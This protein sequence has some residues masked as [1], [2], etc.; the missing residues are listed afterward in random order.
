MG[1]N[2]DNTKYSG[3]TYILPV[4]DQILSATYNFKP[5]SA[6]KAA[7]DT[8]ALSTVTQSFQ[9][10]THVSF[11]IKA[12]GVYELTWP[13]YATI[14]GVKWAGTNL[15]HNNSLESYPWVS[16]LWDGTSIPTPESTLSNDS[17][18]DYWRWNVLNVDLD[19][20]LADLP[21][22]SGTTWELE[23]DPCRQGLGGTWRVPTKD[24]LQSLTDAALKNKWVRINNEEPQRTNKSGWIDVSELRVSGTVHAEKPN[25]VIFLP[26]AGRR[27]GSKYNPTEEREGY[28]W[29]STLD[30]PAGSQS[31]AYYLITWSKNLAVFSFQRYRGAS[32]RC[33][34]D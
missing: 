13:D 1:V 26:A 27:I 21:P 8:K 10:G 22:N 23:K 29:S 25:N 32:L 28:Y 24:N 6:P 7:A 4:N 18:N 12:V 5:T 11:T 31:S 33:V 34:R 19:S 20:S 15:G 9:G 16:G 30:N 17:K 2:A 3:S 14:G